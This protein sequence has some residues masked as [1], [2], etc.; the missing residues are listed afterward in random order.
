MRAYVIKR[1]LILIP[2][3]LLVTFLIF[4][5]IHLMPGDIIDAMLA[6][7]P[8]VEIDRPALERRLGLDAPLPVQYGRWMGVVP[9]MD[10][11]FS[12]ILQ[13]D[14]GVSGWQRMPVVELIAL[15]WPVTL[16][17]GLM[18]LIV[19]LLI[20][21][22]VGIYSALRQDKWGDYIARSFAIACISIPGFWLGTLV[23]V[24]PSIWWGYMPPIMLVKFA[25]DPIRNLGMFIVPAI[26]LGMAMA[27]ITM[28]MTRT[29]ILEVLRQDYIRTAWAKGLRERVVV[30]RHALKNAL[31]PVITIIGI[32]VPLVI[33]G[34]VI[35]EEI[36]SLP[37]MGR[38][39][40]SAVTNRDEPLVSGALLLFAVVLVLTN[41]TIDL[42]YAYLDPRVRYK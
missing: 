15:K 10:G 34:T 13:G 38:L 20:A 16:E 3:L 23:I 12:G 8:D 41:L 37:G 39:I 42:I 40:F 36:F 18:A 2:T 26:I 21:L 31:I 17:L 27:G 30:I 29:M 35:I 5:V 7:N 14:L 9:Q 19:S 28:R 25:E 11:S 22:P 6:A 24:L 32:Q 4:L 1:L 33:G